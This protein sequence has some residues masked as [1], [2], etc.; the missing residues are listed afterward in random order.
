MKHTARIL[1]LALLVIS[2]ASAAAAEDKKDEKLDG[3]A[4]Y[5]AMCKVC[6]DEDADAGEYTPMDLIMEQWDTFFDEDYL[7]AHEEAK[8]EDDSSVVETLTPEMLKAIRQFCVDGAA[9]S[10]HPMTCG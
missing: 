4:L 7:P 8:Y 1:L 3:K 6:H 9:D 5:V 2:L 10:E